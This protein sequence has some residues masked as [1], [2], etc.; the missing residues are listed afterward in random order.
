MLLLKYFIVLFLKATIELDFIVVFCYCTPQTVPNIGDNFMTFIKKDNLQVGST[1]IPS[2]GF[3]INHED[4]NVTVY[5]NDFTEVEVDFSA[6]A[7]EHFFS[8]AMRKAEKDME[9]IK[10]KQKSKEDSING[11]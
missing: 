7:E 3:V 8:Y 4:S 1:G 2:Y 6:I 5:V 9:R 11:K 10:V